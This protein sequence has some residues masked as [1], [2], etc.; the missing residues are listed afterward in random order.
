MGQQKKNS[1]SVCLLLLFY[2]FVWLTFY[3]GL[4]WL[5]FVVLLVFFLF[6]LTFVSVILLDILRA[7][8]IEREHK[9]ED[10]GS[11][12]SSGRYWGRGNH[13]QYV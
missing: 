13:N 6:V 2:F 7:R 4:Y 8:E 12:G 1:M 9:A 5:S 10:E 11:L 3:I